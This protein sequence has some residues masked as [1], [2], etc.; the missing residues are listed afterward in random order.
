[1][2][3]AGLKKVC[4]QQVYVYMLYLQGDIRRHRRIISSL[5][6]YLCHRAHPRVVIDAEASSKPSPVHIWIIFE[7]A[8]V[9]IGF[10]RSHFFYLYTNTLVLVHTVLS[11][12]SNPN[13]SLEDFFHHISVTSQFTIKIIISI[14]IDYRSLF[15]GL[16][17]YFTLDSPD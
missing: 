3:H 12:Q 6:S 13:N 1:M 11:R 9:F 4:R 2:S 8:F 10:I 16:L 14:T 17:L 5:P 15:L 7:F